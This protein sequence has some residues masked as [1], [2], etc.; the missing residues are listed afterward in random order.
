MI[1][2]KTL[3]YK[4]F[5]ST[6]NGW[7]EIDFTKDK[8]TLIV[9]NNGAGKSTMLDA[10]SFALFGKSHRN[11]SKPQLVNSINN[12]DCVVEVEF[13]ALGQEFKITRGIKPNKFEIWRGGQ[14][15]D[16]A[17][18]A[19][20]YQKMLELNILKLNHKSFHQIVVLGSSSFVPFMQL[21]AQNR[22]DVIED[23]LDI[24]VFSK[25]NGILKEKTSGIKNDIREV[26]HEIT[27][28]R[29][30]L[31]AQKK[32][33]SSVK[34]IQSAAKEEKLQLISDIQD[35]VT[36]IQSK[37]GVLSINVESDLPAAQNELSLSSQKIKSLEGYKAKFTADAK[38]I[39][40]D[41][42]FFES[43]S[44]CPTCTQ[45]INEETKNKHVLDGREKSRDLQ[46]AIDQAEEA[47]H[48]ST[49]KLMDANVIV[50]KCR[51]WQSEIH[52]NNQAI[53]IYQNDI[54]R[55]QKEITRLDVSVDLDTAAKEL[56]DIVAKVK[57]QNED[58]L[59]LEEQYRYNFA[60]S[61]MLKDTGIKT[62]IVK[63]YLPVINKLVNQYLQILDF[64][65]SF[66]LDESFS[67]TIKSRHRDTFSYDSFSEGEKQ[68]IDLALLFT[69]RQI[70]K[71]KNSVATNLLILDETFDSS[72]DH[73]GVD[74]LMKIIKS[75]GDDTNI[76][77]ISH[78]GEMLESRF[79]K[80]LEIVKEKNFSKI[81]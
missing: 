14:M 38:K 62:K 6:G 7:S 63:E 26:S 27:I 81:K 68:R 32:Y 77:V 67:E 34:Q 16:Q 17:S 12:K 19:R 58:K 18:H 64:F 51:E 40:K 35:E 9:G 79:A 60:I 69:W 41:V 15:I 72:L 25:M 71:M 75:L 31:D 42:Q 52:K 36:T 54:D 2:F 55:T 61:E 53:S 30:K 46:K 57:K 10:L 28:N 11:I 1:V 44:T 8:T 29:T 39:V 4:N 43:N 80:K 45:D 78:K 74:N 56:K 13:N 70:A 23:L 5:L 47:V 21:T 73:D 59:V 65:V 48:A 3:K 22:R 49:K 24:N 66:H 50:D 33:I 76:F 20:D 37:N